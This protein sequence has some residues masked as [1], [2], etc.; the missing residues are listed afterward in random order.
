MLGAFLRANRRF[1]RLYLKPRLYT[2]SHQGAVEH[3]LRKRVDALARCDSLLEFGSGRE[4]P[5]AKKFGHRF[6]AV[7]AT[8]IDDVPQVQWPSGVDFKRCTTTQVPFESD[9]FDVVVVWSV[10]E[11]VEEPDLVF[12]EFARVL[13]PGGVVLMNVPNKWDYVSVAARL[14]GPFKSRVLRGAIV[15]K[16]D[17]FPVFYRANTR[18]SLSALARRSGLDVRLFRPLPSEPNYLSF[19]VPLYVAGAI[20]QFLISLLFL[21]VLQP[22]FLVILAKPDQRGDS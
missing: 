12:G 17:D 15:P 13:R 10:I 22:A 6:T 14:A 20:Y 8:D 1:C 18:R 11:H 3:W 9:R 7:A 16:W 19:F 2:V 21:D 5:V 4:F